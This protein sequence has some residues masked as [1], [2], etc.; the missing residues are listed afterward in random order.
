MAEPHGCLVAVQQAVLLALVEASVA[1]VADASLEHGHLHAAGDDGDEGQELARRRGEPSDPTHGQLRHRSRY[2]RAA[3]AE[4]FGD[5]QRVATAELGEPRHGQLGAAR[6]LGDGGFAQR[7]QVDADQGVAREFTDDVRQRL[8]AGQGD[9]PAGHD[10]HPVAVGDPAPHMTHQIDGR[11]ISPVGV[12]D[13]QHRRNRSPQQGEHLGEHPP[14]VVG[15]ER[16]E[17]LRSSIGQV[18]NGAERIGCGDVVAAPDQDVDAP[19]MLGREVPDE[20]GLAHAGVT[21]DHDDAPVTGCRARQRVR[22]LRQLARALEQLHRANSTGVSRG[23]T[24]ARNDRRS[25]LPLARAWPSVIRTG[26][27]PDTTPPHRPRSTPPHTPR[28]PPRPTAP[29]HPPS[30]SISW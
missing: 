17:Q 2:V 6:Q 27:H 3:G 9:V 5:E 4:Q 19:G 25:P 12:L 10:Q 1:R 30:W 23:P 13:D 7:R 26:E 28:R 16:P 24:P 14:T 22:Q 20:T 15:L 18:P 8:A 21:P 11:L 29:R